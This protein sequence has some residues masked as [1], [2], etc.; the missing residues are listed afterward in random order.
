MGR[1]NYEHS[2]VFFGT[3]NVFLQIGSDKAV[4]GSKGFL[5]LDSYCRE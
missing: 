4:G 5:P 3:Y 1:A 2:S